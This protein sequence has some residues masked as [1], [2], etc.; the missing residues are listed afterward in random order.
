[1]EKKAYYILWGPSEIRES[2]GLVG[3]HQ[4]ERYARVEGQ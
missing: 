2:E 1:M 4:T 3:C